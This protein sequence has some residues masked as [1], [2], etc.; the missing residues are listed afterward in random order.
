MSEW[1]PCPFCGGTDI[2]SAAHQDSRS[3]TGF[4]YSMCCYAC[5]ATFPNRYKAELLKSAWNRRT[6]CNAAERRL[7]AALEPFARFFK[8]EEHD[9]SPASD[10]TIVATFLDQETKLP[11]AELYI[12]HFREAARALS[13]NQGGETCC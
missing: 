11:L 8:S 12:S 13:P 3:P 5:G 2:R 1:R 9:L 10:T 4:I 7:Q 6:C